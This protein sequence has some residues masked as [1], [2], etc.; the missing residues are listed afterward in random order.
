MQ[1][2]IFISPFNGWVKISSGPLE[3]LIVW[4]A[5]Q[6]RPNILLFFVCGSC[7]PHESVQGKHEMR[8]ETLYSTFPLHFPV[9]AKGLFARH[10][11]Q[12]LLICQ[13]FRWSSS[14]QKFLRFFPAQNQKESSIRFIHYTVQIKSGGLFRRNYTKW[15]PRQFYLFS[16]II[17]FMLFIP[18]VWSC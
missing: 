9:L 7:C 14:G 1:I 2:W 16:R 4:Q 10:F 3:I 5:F 12:G 8:V 15:R 6:P 17:V 13:H 11:W 18:F